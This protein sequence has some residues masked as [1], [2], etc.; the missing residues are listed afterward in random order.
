MLRLVA[1]ALALSVA[2]IP[3]TVYPAAP[4]TWLVLASLLTVAAGVTLLAVPLVAAG[5]VLALIA[6]AVALLIAPPALDV[7]GAIALGVALTLLLS[8]VDVAAR[9]DG[10]AL[11]PSLL[12]W[13]AREWAVVTAAGGLAAGAL[14]LGGFALA[15]AARGASPPVV[16]AAAALGAALAMAG[17]IAVARKGTR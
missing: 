1:A 8:I 12:V 7:A 16:V 9:L 15:D 17:A 14:T 5:G 6:H 13:Q 4:V 3:L 10:A 2:A 11:G